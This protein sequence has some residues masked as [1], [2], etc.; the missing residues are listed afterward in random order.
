MTACHSLFTIAYYLLHL[1]IFLSF[2][3]F[4]YLFVDSQHS[5]TFRRINNFYCR[6]PPLMVAFILMD[7]ASLFPPITGPSLSYQSLP[8]LACSETVYN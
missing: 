6:L 3:G 7:A 2:A 1:Y 5:V 4:N 8:Y